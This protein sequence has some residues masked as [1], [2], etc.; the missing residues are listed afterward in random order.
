MTTSKF[1]FE[2]ALSELEKITETLSANEVPLEKAIDQYEK[3][4][5]LAG[6]ALKQLNTSEKKVKQVIEKNGQLEL[7]DFKNTDE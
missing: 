7:I 4:V 1:D 6:E 2:K 3:G 5:K